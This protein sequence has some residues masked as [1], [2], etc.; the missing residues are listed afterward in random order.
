MR[1]DVDEVIAGAC[2]V[3]AK[4]QERRTPEAGRVLPVGP[5]PCLAVI[6]RPGQLRITGVANPEVQDSLDAENPAGLPAGLA[7][8]FLF[9]RGRADVHAIDLVWLARDSG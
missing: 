5:L 9:Q 6:A 7:F 3:P 1:I 4:I 8:P 2:V